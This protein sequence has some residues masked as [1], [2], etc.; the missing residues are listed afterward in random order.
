VDLESQ[1]RSAGIQ[2]QV[3]GRAKHL[4]SIWRKMQAKMISM[5][6][7]YDVRAVRVL[8]PDIA[9]CYAALGV[10]HT[11]WKHIPREFDDYV[12]AP[13]DNGYRSI[14]TAVIG[15]GDRTLE[16]QIRTYE[17]HEEAELGLC[18]HWAYKDGTGTKQ[19]PKLPLDFDLS[20]DEKLGWIRQLLEWPDGIDPRTLGALP[21]P[22]SDAKE[23]VFVFTPKGH[24]L[25]FARGATPI[26]FAYRVHTEVG[27]RCTGALVNEAPLALNVPLQTGQRVEILC[28]D[29]AQPNRMWLESRLGFVKTGRAQQ[30]LADYFCGLPGDAQRELGACLVRRSMAGLGLQDPDEHLLARIA[31]EQGFVSTDALLTALGQGTLELFDV[32]PLIL[33]HAGSPQLPLI[34]DA[35]AIG[36][37]PG[38]QREFAIALGCQDRDGLLRDVALLLSRESAHLRSTSARADG[39][40]R[41][42]MLVEVQLKDLLELA[43]IIELLRTVPGVLTVHRVL[44]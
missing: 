12:A 5:D 15:P 9:S 37:V 42:R 17:M 32:L 14:H 43:R 4:H 24:V 25:D 16:V 34:D 7:V 26:D 39:E 33:E 30:K 22:A 40:G 27:H 36:S 6:E 44:H 41:A 29:A 8:V 31:G 20:Y 35:A 19:A 38:S 13:K 2:A 18:A 21:P 11:R 3:T 10:I 23:R 28:A 1:L